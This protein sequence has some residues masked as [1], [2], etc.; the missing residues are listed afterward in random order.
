ML[1]IKTL[2]LAWLKDALSVLV[3]HF[4]RNV[5]LPHVLLK[6]VALNKL[7]S[8]NI[9]DVETVA[10]PITGLRIDAPLSGGSSQ[11][12]DLIASVRIAGKVR[13]NLSFATKYCSWHNPTAYPID[14]PPEN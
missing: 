2:R 13:Y 8:T 7:Y 4:P 10:R 6:V 3:R 9:L 14:L 11:A 1:S 5:E 12:V